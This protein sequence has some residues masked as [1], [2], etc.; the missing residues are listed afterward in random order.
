LYGISCS[1][2]SLCWAVGENYNSSTGQAV[3]WTAAVGW[4][5]AQS[6][7]GATV[8][9]GISCLS[10]SSCW[11]VGKNSSNVGVVYNPFPSLS[12]TWTAPSGTNTDPSGTDALGY[13]LVASQQLV[14]ASYSNSTCGTSWTS[15]TSGLGASATSATVGSPSSSECYSVQAVGRD[16]YWTS[17][18][19]TGVPG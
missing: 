2:T 11:A 15:I 5:A 1:S 16:T 9:N 19:P 6:I 4:E 10:T 8:L 17:A 13:P 14:E 7:S 18:V 12:L 3:E